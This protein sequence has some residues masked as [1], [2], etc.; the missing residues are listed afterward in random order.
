MESTTE[1]R[2]GFVEALAYDGA[3]YDE[4]DDLVEPRT[5]LWVTGGRVFLTGETDLK[6][7]SVLAFRY[8]ESE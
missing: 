6:A 3:E 8:R 2:S 7:D 1:E 4:N 5:V